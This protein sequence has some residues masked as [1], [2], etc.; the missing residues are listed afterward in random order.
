[1]TQCKSNLAKEWDFVNT[2]YGTECNRLENPEVAT[3]QDHFTTDTSKRMDLNIHLI[4][5]TV[6]SNT[7]NIQFCDFI[8]L[9]KC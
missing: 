8:L 2:V 4:S 9:M 5:L 7:I 1:M 6:M 3:S